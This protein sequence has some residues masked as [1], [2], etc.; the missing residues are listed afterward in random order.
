MI[1]VLLVDDH[2]MM[3]HLLRQMVETYADLT[4]VG[5]A[6]NGED[7]VTQAAALQPSVVLID[8]H[9]PAMT[10][11]QATKLIKV[12]S[13]C[14]A[15]IGLTAGAPGESKLTMIAAGAAAVIDKAEVLESLYPLILDVVRQLK[16]PV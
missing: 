16:N 1:D 10:G 9:L 3:R 12:L 13:P 14:S 6:E 2:P 4:I 8:V 11:I 7:A 5:E 15:V